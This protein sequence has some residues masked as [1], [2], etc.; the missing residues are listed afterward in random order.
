MKEGGYPDKGRPESK[1]SSV[2]AKLRSAEKEKT[3]LRDRRRRAITT[4]IFSGLRKYGGYNLPPR[5]DINDVLTALAA[6]PGWIVESDVSDYVDLFNIIAKVFPRRKLLS[7][8]EVMGRGC[9]I[10]FPL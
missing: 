2:L 9:M 3:K 8:I 6:D 5:A 7:S 1:D 10:S 4:K